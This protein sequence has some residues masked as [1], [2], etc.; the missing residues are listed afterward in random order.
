[1]ITIP[2]TDTTEK[3]KKNTRSY[4]YPNSIF[5]MFLAGKKL[6]AA[7]WKEGSYIYL[8]NNKLVDQDKKVVTHFDIERSTYD[9]YFDE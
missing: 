3:P 9:E 7:H 2:K 5:E 1:M 4:Y 6:R 8:L